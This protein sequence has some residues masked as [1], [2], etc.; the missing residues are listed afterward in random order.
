MFLQL[1]FL[2]PLNHK[3][4]IDTLVYPIAKKLEDFVGTFECPQTDTHWTL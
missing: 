4:A 2:P 3:E 1:A